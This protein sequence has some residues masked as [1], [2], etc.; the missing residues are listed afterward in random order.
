MTK[1]I[2]VT[3]YCTLIVW[4]TTELYFRGDAHSGVPGGGA[5]EEQH[6][7]HHV[8]HVGAGQVPHSVGALLL[9]CTGRV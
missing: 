3:P 8:R 7:L 9:R 2:A 4:R 1:L 6:Q 5:E